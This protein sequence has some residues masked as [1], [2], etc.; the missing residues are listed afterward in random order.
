[1]GDVPKFVPLIANVCPQPA[2]VGA[3]EL[4][5][6]AGSAVGTGVAVSAAAPHPVTVNGTV[7]DAPPL[8]TTTR[9]KPLPATRPLDGKVAVICVFEPPIRLSRIGV[10]EPGG[11][12]SNWMLVPNVDGG[13]PKLLP[14][15]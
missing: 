7:L 12:P 11:P 3:T 13:V 4:T 9:L 8:L 1:M 15:T 14:V 10:P 2:E 5:D 6:G